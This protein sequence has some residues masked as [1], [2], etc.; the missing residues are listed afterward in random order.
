MNIFKRFAHQSERPSEVRPAM[1]A[2]MCE[3]ITKVLRWCAESSEGERCQGVSLP[4]ISMTELFRASLVGA[5]HLFARFQICETLSATSTAC[6][7][8]LTPTAADPCFTCAQL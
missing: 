7:A 5:L 3:S 4:V 2:P 1:P 6:V 8:F